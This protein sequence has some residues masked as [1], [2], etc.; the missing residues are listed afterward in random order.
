MPERH[1]R[2]AILVVAA[3]ISAGVRQDRVEIESGEIDK[4]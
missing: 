2:P 3:A 1:D 4:N